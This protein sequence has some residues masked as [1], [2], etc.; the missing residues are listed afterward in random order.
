VNRGMTTRQGGRPITRPIRRSISWYGRT[1]GPPTSKVPPPG[2]VVPGARD[3]V[4]DQVVPV[5]RL[6]GGVDP[7]R[8]DHERQTLDQLD[9]HLEGSAAG[10]EDDPGAQLGHRDAARPEDLADLPAALEV[11]G[12]DRRVVPEAPEIDD[13][14]DARRP[15]GIGKALR[16]RPLLLGQSPASRRAR[17]HGVDKVVRDPDPLE[18]PG[19][20]RPVPDIPL[21]P[22]HANVGHG[23]PPDRR[24]IEPPNR[25]PLGRERPDESTPDEP[26][27]PG[28]E[29]AVRAGTARHP[30]GCRRRP[31]PHGPRQGREAYRL[32]PP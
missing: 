13:P 8:A 23:R 29:G 7:P 9:H 17:P 14:L 12:G 3:Q 31:A 4:A 30:I 2:A 25:E 5:N 27:G 28:D 10:A 22:V 15:R 16:C 21:D 20:G 6:A 24:A 11:L 19:D 32:G 18:G 1:S 26:R